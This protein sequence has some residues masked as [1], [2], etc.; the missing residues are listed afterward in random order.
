MIRAGSTS[1]WQM[2]VAT[3][4]WLV[5][6][7]AVGASEG[8]LAAAW[9]V[10]RGSQ[11]GLL[12]HGTPPAGAAAPGRVRARSRTP[13]CTLPYCTESSPSLNVSEPCTCDHEMHDLPARAWCD[14][15]YDRESMFGL[16]MTSAWVGV[17]VLCNMSMSQPFLVYVNWSGE[18]IHVE[19]E[20]WRDFICHFPMLYNHAQHIHYNSLSNTLFPRSMIPYHGIQ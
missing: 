6:A 19:I 2:P 9:R 5:W 1:A 11:T 12:P 4:A 10:P 17:C 15:W 7:R 8:H 3:Q 18:A 14:K 20:Q 16:C 13:Y